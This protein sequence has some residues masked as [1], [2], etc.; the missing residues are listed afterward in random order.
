MQIW[1]EI[2]ANSIN[3]APGAAGRALVGYS[4]CFVCSRG[5]WDQ[6]L[7]TSQVLLEEIIVAFCVTVNARLYPI[8]SHLNKITR[9]IFNYAARYSTEGRIKRN[10][11]DHMITYSRISALMKI[12]TCDDFSLLFNKSKRKWMTNALMSI[13]KCFGFPRPKEKNT[14]LEA[15]RELP[16]KEN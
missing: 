1:D 9:L 12:C 2:H 5:K 16:Q 11:M 3:E 14:K 4:G 8:Y 13:A 7:N 6:P 15:P 10:H